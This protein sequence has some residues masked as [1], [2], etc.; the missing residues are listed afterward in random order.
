LKLLRNLLLAG[1]AAITFA[2]T[3]QAG[4]SGWERQRWSEPGRAWTVDYLVEP[5]TCVLARKHT[6]GTFMQFMYL[7]K[8]R[9]FMLTVSNDQWSKI[10]DGD[11]YKVT[12]IM[13]GG[14]DRWRGDAQ[15]IWTYDGHPGW[16]MA[17]LSEGFIRSFIQ[18]NRVD[19]YNNSGDWVTALGLDGTAAGILALVECLDT[20]N[21]GKG[22]SQPA[23]PKR[24]EFGA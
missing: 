13:D 23:K 7:P 2:T 14:A 17:P 1:T 12:M 21:S 5:N 6:D 11:T 9:G 3:A 22:Q 10:K 18:R 16:V 4:S 15:G 19:F 20:H 24:P 8:E